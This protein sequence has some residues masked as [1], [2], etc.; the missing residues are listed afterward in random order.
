MRKRITTGNHGERVRSDCSVTLELRDKG[1]IE[2]KLESKVE[3]MFGTQIRGQVGEV[4]ATLGVS[5]ALV[6]IK[7]TGALPFV[8]AARLEAAVRQFNEP[9]QSHIPE[10]ISRNLYETERERT[11]FSRLYL[12]GNSP[13]MMLNAGIHQPDGIILDLEDSVAPDKK[14]EASVLVRNALC[15]VDFYGA[16][17][18][19][20][21]NQLPAGLKDLDYIIPHHVHLVLIPKC[22]SGDQVREVDDRIRAILK[23]CGQEREVHLMPII[24]SALGVE[25][26]FEIASAS[27]SVVAM[28]I[29]LE[30]YTADLGVARTAGGD[31]SLYARTRMVNA[32]KAAGIQPIDSVFSDVAD[33]E[34]LKANVERSRALGFEGMGCIHPRQVPVIQEGFT[35]TAVEIEKAK[36]IIKAFEEAESKGLGVI[37]LGTKMIDPPVVKRAQ[38]TMELAIRFGLK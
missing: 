22:E 13:S 19:V 32:C 9:A 8:L 10:I 5:D 21:I 34:G 23:E 17:R 25:R 18:M 15:Q 2:L 38:R 6:E 24:E 12:P 4:L 31:E 37:S 27:E 26:A 30:D 36:R 11:R 7:D 3:R 33:M 29:G 20:R 14:A 28:A 35:P 1:G 16:E